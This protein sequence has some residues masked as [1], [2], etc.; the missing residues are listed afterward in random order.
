MVAQF[1]NGALIGQ[2]VRLLLVAS[3]SLVLGAI[4]PCLLPEGDMTGQP[5]HDNLGTESTMTYTNDDALLT[6]LQQ[7]Q[8]RLGN[9]KLGGIGGNQDVDNPQN[10]YHNVDA[11]I[12]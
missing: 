2:P 9:G 6:P 7:Q 12:V 4:T 11:L 3:L 10:S 5:V 1:V 8:H